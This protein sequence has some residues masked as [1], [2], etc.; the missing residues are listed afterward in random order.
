MTADAKALP[1][2]QVKARAI[3]K[4]EAKG[5]TLGRWRPSSVYVGNRAYNYCEKCNAQV[6]VGRRPY[7]SGDRIRG[8]A[9]RFRCQ[10]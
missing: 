4:A 6:I 2:D 1:L 8:N 7:I 3:E 10:Q 9:V 5:H